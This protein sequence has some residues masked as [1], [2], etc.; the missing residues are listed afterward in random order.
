MKFKLD[1]NLPLELADDILRLGHD[2]DS[3]HGENL[4]GADDATVVRAAFGAGRIL[5]TLDKGIASLLR[6][7]LQNH[8]GVVLFRP[9]ASG[10]REVLSF[11]RLRL[12]NLLE[13]ESNGRLT[14]VGPTQIRVR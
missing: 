4:D 9:D 13:M 2:A 1:E 11:V 6:Y 3:V 7:P 10:R 14:V 5:I 8:A 12:D